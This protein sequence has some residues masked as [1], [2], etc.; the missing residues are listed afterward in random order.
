MSTGGEGGMLVTND[1]NVFRKA[2]IYKDHGKNIDKYNNIGG[3]HAAAGIIGSSYSSLGTNWRLTEMQAAIGNLQLAKLP[4]WIERR[5]K[6]A[7]ILE[8]GL[9]DVYGL[10]V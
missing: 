10:L 7:G 4:E 6:F 5:R 8:Q 3:L 1:K 9:I 2:W